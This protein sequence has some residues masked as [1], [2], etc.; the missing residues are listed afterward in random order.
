M[1]A[2][3]MTL[4]MSRVEFYSELGKNLAAILSV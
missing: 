2:S 3:E 4:W 1:N